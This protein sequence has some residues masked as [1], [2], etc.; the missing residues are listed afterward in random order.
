MGAATIRGMAEPSNKWQRW[1]DTENAIVLTFRA[2]EAAALLGRTVKA[3]Y[4]R[5]SGKSL[6]VIHGNQKPKKK[7]RREYFATGKGP[8]EDVVPP[9]EKPNCR[10][11]VGRSIYLSSQALR[12]ASL[13]VRA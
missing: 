2:P 10:F 13:N 4:H 3:V 11:C 9:P 1:T 5:R 12:P 7:L 8:R 6:G